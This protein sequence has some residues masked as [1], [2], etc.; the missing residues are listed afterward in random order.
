[1]ASQVN[2]LSQSYSV[3]EKIGARSSPVCQD[4]GN[5]EKDDDIDDV[6]NDD[7][8]MLL[9]PVL[10]C[11]AHTLPPVLSLPHARNVLLAAVEGLQSNPPLLSSGIIRFQVI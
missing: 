10:M 9:D 1:M 5:K 2:C 11:E 7:D 8:D 6:I 3:T 4:D